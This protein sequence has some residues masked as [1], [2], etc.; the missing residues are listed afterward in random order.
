MNLNS[1]AFVIHIYI[2]IIKLIIKLIRFIFRAVFH[3]PKQPAITKINKKKYRKL[4]KTAD[5]DSEIASK[6]NDEV[7]I[8]DEVEPSDLI[9]KHEEVLTD[10]V[11]GVEKNI[12]KKSSLRSG[13]KKSIVYSEIINRK[14]I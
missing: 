6:V 2:L 8:N 14:Y 12:N 3:I 7:E 1:Y 11:I 9:N 13:L 5:F 10:T 4:T